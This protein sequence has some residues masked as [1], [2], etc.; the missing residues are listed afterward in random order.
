MAGEEQR[1]VDTEVVYRLACTTLHVT[2]TREERTAWDK[3]EP[4]VVADAAVTLAVEAERRGVVQL[5]EFDRDH[6][7]EV[8]LG[9]D[10][11]L[12]GASNSSQGLLGEAIEATLGVVSFAAGLVGS[13]VSPGLPAVPAPGRRAVRT[14]AIERVDPPQTP[15]EKWVALDLDGDATRLK[16][17]LTT[18]KALHNAVV[19]IAAEAATSPYPASVYRRLIAVR[20][21]I[22]EVE[23][24]VAAINT[25][26]DAWH[27]QNFVKSRDFETQIPSD[28]LF[29]HEVDSLTPPDT[30]P[31]EAVARG[32]ARAKAA[33]EKLDVAIVELRTRG[34]GDR[35]DTDDALDQEAIDRDQRHG[36]LAAGI[37]FRIPRS[38]LIALYVRKA[39]DT[40]LELHS[41]DWYWLVDEDSRLGSF[42]LDRGEKS[43]LDVAATFTSEGLLQTLSMDAQGRLAVVLEALKNA[44][45]TI[46]GGLEQAEKAAKSWDSLRSVRADRELKA[47]EN[48]KKQL[49]AAVA[50]RGLEA[51]ASE[52]KTLQELKDKLERLKTQRDIGKIESPAAPDEQEKLDAERRELARRLKTELLIEL[53]ENALA[54]F[55]DGAQPAPPG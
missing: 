35:A 41:A 55:Q 53:R 20:G 8:K 24:E 12:T 47:L 31:A 54:T 38:G 52:L 34:L 14:A 13:I 5:P 1:Q 2:G 33:L 15:A 42:P 36:N 23:T 27:A 7:F 26:R 17:A 6:A 40:P 10:G 21:A 43:S 3:T 25:R 18:L 39:K 32:P 11:R 37:W 45:A 28:A 19:D 30:I 16:A 48:R 29:V 51:D 49:E 4:H 22:A 50:A 46:A 9:P 44:P